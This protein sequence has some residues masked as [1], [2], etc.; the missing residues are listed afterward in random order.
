[1]NDWQRRSFLASSAALAAGGIFATSASGEERDAEPSNPV[2]DSTGWSSYRGNAANTASVETAASSELDT[3][4]WKY[5]ETGD[6]AAA[7]GRA[8]LRTDDGAVH[9]LDA[10]T[11]DLEW[12]REDLNVDGTPAVAN[13][14]VYVTGERLV[15]LD[16][17]AGEVVW[18]VEFDSSESVT[19]PTV[20]HETVYVVANGSLYAIDAHDGSVNWKYDSIEIAAYQGMAMDSELEERSFDSISAAVA[21]ET[22]YAHT[23]PEAL[24]A[25]E[26]TTGIKL[27][28]ADFPKGGGG[29][30][31]VA[32]EETIYVKNLEIGHRVT[33]SVT[34]Y[35]GDA[36][37]LLG[38]DG[39]VPTRTTGDAPFATSNEV[40]LSR[41]RI[42][43]PLG[44]WDYERGEYRWKYD[45][46]SGIFAFRAPVIAGETAIVSYHPPSAAETD[47]A[48]KFF[49]E[50]GSEPA[51]LGLDLTDGSK[52]WVIPYEGAGDVSVHRNSYEPPYVVSDDA[53]YLTTSDGLFAIRSSQDETTH[54]SRDGESSGDTEDGETET[55]DRERTGDDS[56]QNEPSIETEP[57]TG[58]TDTESVGD[59][60]P[61]QDDVNETNESD[62]NS[63][64]NADDVPGFTGGASVVGG[65]LGLEWLRRRAP[66]DETDE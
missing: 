64:A 10:G 16:G 14:T 40:R 8:Y 7:N 15:A 49:E 58:S 52:K 23:S 21:N 29:E 61:S 35:E 31:I 37:R 22:V 4:A 20:A 19:Q 39:E 59:A 1:M 13:E 27:W 62:V 11:G 6:L 53:L 26:A 25:L 66:R 51:I 63:D 9:A 41:P 47:E 18:E 43:E 24:V 45:V 42:S 3:F 57:D 65:T 54:E 48:K 60:Q 30:P 5:E 36:E 38:H 17:T 55:D 28:T 34:E 50:F 32:T 33:V 56:D 2:T 46:F 12:K 44:A